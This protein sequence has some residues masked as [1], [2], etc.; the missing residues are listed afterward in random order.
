[1]IFSTLLPLTPIKI[2]RAEEGLAMARDR[3]VNQAIQNALT[4]IRTIAEGQSERR[5]SGTVRAISLRTLIHTLFR[6]KV[7][8]REQ[9]PQE[10]AILA[11]N[12]LNHIDPFLLLSEV[13][14]SPFYYILGDARTLYNQYWK[15]QILGLSGGVIPLERRWGEELA[16]I[17]S[18][19]AGEKDLVNL[20]TAIEK[21]IPSGSD[22]AM[23]RYI[24][25]AVQ[26]I[27]ARGD[28]IILFPEGRLGMAEGQLQLPLKRG[29][30]LYA[31][32]SGVP[33]VPVALIGTKHLYFKKELTIRFGKPLYFP[34]SKRPKRKEVETVLE[35]LKES[36]SA[37]LPANYQEPDEPKLFSD[38]LNR[39]FY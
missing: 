12:H 24:E 36:L 39:M 27:L 35:A 7:E 9:I 1:M 37:L 34:S 15:R 28:G 25:R 10:A 6:I 4:Q 2:K 17:E 16:V 8:Y 18:A 33:I 22:I 31:L 26:A 20:A 21:E 29:I 23:L 30:A 19:K 38:F 14:K 13:P 5:V 32:R 3:A 11:P